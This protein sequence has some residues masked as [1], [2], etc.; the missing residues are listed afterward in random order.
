[1]KKNADT[2]KPPG[3]E[4]LIVSFF[5][6]SRASAIKKSFP[7]IYAIYYRLK[8]SLRRKLEYI[9]SLVDKY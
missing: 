4:K 6:V 8:Y 9:L 3:S 5:V 1:M 7:R 2:Y